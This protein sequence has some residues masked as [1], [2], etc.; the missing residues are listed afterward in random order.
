MASRKYLHIPHILQRSHRA[1]VCP[2]STLF[3][4]G[5][6]A[7]FVT[8]KQPCIFAFFNQYQ[9]SSSQEQKLPEA[10]AARFSH[11]HFYVDH[12]SPLATYKALELQM[13]QFSENLMTNG[14]VVPEKV[15][16]VLFFPSAKDCCR[17]V[18][19][20]GSLEYGTP[21]FPGQ[22]I[23]GRW[24]P[25]HY[26]LGRE[27]FTDISATCGTLSCYVRNDLPGLSFN[28]TLK[29]FKKRKPE[30]MQHS[31]FVNSF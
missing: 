24:K 30:Y 15:F 6:F 28:G 4:R 7:S 19:G 2:S 14:N 21:N 16:G 26:M 25:L 17:E 18:G 5:D 9:M 8:H 1:L 12:L 27:I 31:R 29:R 3:A 11:V 22:V 13:N 23:G 10:A 20:W